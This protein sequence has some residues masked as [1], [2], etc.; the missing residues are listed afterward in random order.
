MGN[1]SQ[2]SKGFVGENPTSI[3][4]AQDYLLANQLE[5]GSASTVEADVNSAGY[6]QLSSAISQLVRNTTER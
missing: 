4:E 2:K 3:A 6:G 1:D 5:F